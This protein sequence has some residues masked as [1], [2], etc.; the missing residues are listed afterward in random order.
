MYASSAATLVHE[1]LA[2]LH[3]ATARQRTHARTHARTVCV[4]QKRQP[5]SQPATQQAHKQARK[6]ESKTARQQESNQASK[7]AAGRWRSTHCW[8]IAD[9]NALA[10]SMSM[11]FCT[12][13]ISEPAEKRVSF[14][15]CFSPMFVPSLSW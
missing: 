3:R 2:S 8:L 10:A 7:R 13:S 9:S 14:C 5:A 6:Q 4:C 1:A 15:E 11:G 12:S